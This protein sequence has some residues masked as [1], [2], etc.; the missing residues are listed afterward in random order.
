MTE[1]NPSREV[2]YFCNGCGSKWTDRYAAHCHRCHEL[3]SSEAG[4]LNRHYDARG[5]CLEPSARGF[6]LINQRNGNKVW[7]RRGIGKLTHNEATEWQY[8]AQMEAAK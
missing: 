4:M 5:R 8:R 3:F 7:S 6:A 1:P 2:E